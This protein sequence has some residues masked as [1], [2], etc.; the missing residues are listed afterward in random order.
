M[1]FL[2][3]RR[4]HGIGLRHPSLHLQ[5]QPLQKPRCESRLRA[6]QHQ[7]LGSERIIYH[8]RYVGNSRLHQRCEYAF[9][10]AP[11]NIRSPAKAFNLFMTATAAGIVETFVSLSADP[12][13]V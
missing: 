9:T 10:K 4:S 1:W 7:C 12:L 8:H 6:K 3:R 2:H 5:R 11:R 13:L